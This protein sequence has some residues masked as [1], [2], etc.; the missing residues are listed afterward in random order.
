MVTGSA[1]PAKE[2]DST[3]AIHAQFV[4]AL[5]LVITAPV[6][7]AY[8]SELY[9]FRGSGYTAADLFYDQERT[10]YNRRAAIPT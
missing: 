4:Q 2:Q 3:V 5:E 10:A 7:V 1:I 8:N 6:R 9:N